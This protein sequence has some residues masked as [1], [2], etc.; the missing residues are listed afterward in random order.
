MSDE[1][2]PEPVG[3]A[4]EPRADV[5]KRRADATRRRTVG[6]VIVASLVVLGLVTGL[7]SV[8][9]YVRLNGNIDKVDV[10]DKID[11]RLEKKG[12][13]GQLNVLVLGSDTRSGE[14]N[15]IDQEAG[16]GGSDTT[17]LLHLSADRTRA[18]AVSIPRD[19]LV[20]RPDCGADNAVSGGEERKW[21]EAFALG[22]AHDP[23]GGG[24]ACAVEQVEA[25]TGV[26]V[27]YYVVVDFNGFKEMVDAL[28]GVPVCIP[29][30]IEDPDAKIFIEA[31]EREISGD[32]ALDYVRVR[33]NIGDES[34]LGRIKRQQA[35]M[36]AMIKKATSR[37]ILARPDKLFAFLDAVTSAVQTD[38]ES[39]AQLG[40]LAR[41]LQSIGLDNV[42]FL[43]VPWEYVRPSYDVVWVEPRATRLWKLLVADEPLPARF[44]DGSLTAAN[45]PGADPVPTP[46]EAP[47]ETPSETPSDTAAPAPSET[48]EGFEIDEEA[49]E[50]AGLCT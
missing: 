21:N 24:P 44:T 2:P 48:P 27:D 43:T 15:A 11:E 7:A 46:P 35:F 41:Q 45:A 36:A 20:T 37:G 6:R 8:Y 14:G 13:E 40:G 3:A 18:Y 49:A 17:V 23:D 31:G 19:S 50:D 32:E 1:S 39:V 25:T 30:D 28:D 16:A 38:F 42:K 4:P 29:E 12:P 33:K 22:Q 10:D 47:Q 5:P 9:A 34:D 26:P